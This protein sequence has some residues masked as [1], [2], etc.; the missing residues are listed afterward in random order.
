[1]IPCAA[2]VVAVVVRTQATAAYVS[3]SNQCTLHIYSDHTDKHV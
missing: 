1:M 2:A 3:S